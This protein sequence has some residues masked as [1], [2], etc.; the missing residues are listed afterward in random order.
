MRLPAEHFDLVFSQAMFHFVQRKDQAV[1]EIV[2][3]LKAGAEAH[4]QVDR[5]GAD[6][7]DCC[8]RF[9]IKD[10]RRR[11]LT[12]DYLAGGCSDFVRIDWRWSEGRNGRRITVLHAGKARVRRVRLGPTQTRPG[13][14]SWKRTTGPAGF[15]TATAAS[16]RRSPPAPLTS[17]TKPEASL[18]RGPGK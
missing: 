17:S 1:E 6:A 14:G 2:R 4:V 5:T 13:P 10:E 8:P 16:S 3:V 18:R 15:S 7:A 12:P 11:I 9:V